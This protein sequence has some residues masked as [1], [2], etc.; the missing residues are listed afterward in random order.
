[1]DST[2]YTLTLTPEQYDLVTHR[3][4]DMPDDDGWGTLQPFPI[5]KEDDD[6]HPHPSS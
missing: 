6:D 2:T 3:L 1:M 5:G 4:A